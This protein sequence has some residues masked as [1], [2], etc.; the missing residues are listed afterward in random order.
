MNQ[1]TQAIP[2][3]QKTLRIPYRLSEK[4]QAS[5]CQAEM[6]IKVSDDPCKYRF[7]DRRAWPVPAVK[8]DWT[9]T[10]RCNQSRYI[11]GDAELCMLVF[12]AEV[13]RYT[14]TNL[15]IRMA[16]VGALPFVSK[17]VER[18]RAICHCQDGQA[19]NGV[20]V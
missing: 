4:V 2:W 16:R 3:H 5:F 18:E 8:N 11:L 15:L 12:Q 9:F 19:Q 7:A 17:T 10:C 1:D 13:E 14:A 6:P 20:R